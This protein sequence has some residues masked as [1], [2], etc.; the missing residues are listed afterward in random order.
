MDFTQSCQSP[1]TVF[2]RRTQ[3]FSE[4]FI[5]KR[6]RKGRGPRAVETRTEWEESVGLSFGE[7]SV[8]G[9]AGQWNREPRSCLAPR[10]PAD[11][12]LLLQRSCRSSSVEEVRGATSSLPGAPSSLASLR[13]H[14]ALW[15]FRPQGAVRAVLVA[16]LP[17]DAWNEGCGSCW[18]GGAC[19]SSLHPPG[20]ALWLRLRPPTSP[21]LPPYLS[22]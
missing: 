5:V 11:L 21:A 1:G 16:R 10:W 8:E 15:G 3:I 2:C 7:P 18:R 12:L 4:V 17:V 22:G 13:G 6:T 20:L 14:R 9:N 19:A